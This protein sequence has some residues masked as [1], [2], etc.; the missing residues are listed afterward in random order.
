MHFNIE[1]MLDAR[2]GEVE[3]LMFDAAY[4]EY[5]KASHSGVRNIEVV[6]QKV[7]ADRITRVVRY[8]PKPIIE[9][10]GPK[11]VPV[12]AMVFT[13][14]S[15][16]DRAAHRLSFRNVPQMPFVREHLTN[17]GTISF[18]ERAGGTQRVAEGEL[19]VKVPILGAIAERI[20]FTQARKLLDEEVACFKRFILLSRE[21]K[22]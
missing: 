14:H 18:A 10:V 1:N 20:I 16:Y 7:E 15:T 19:K 21:K 11:K 22:A 5:L 9:K 12:E 6:E 3:A 8:T 17:E 13:E 2:L 4:Y